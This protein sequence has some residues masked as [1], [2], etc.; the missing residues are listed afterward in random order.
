MAVP[1]AA[2]EHP[3][4][5]PPDLRKSLYIVEY[6]VGKAHRDSSF[7]VSERNSDLGI[8]AADCGF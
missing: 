2:A 5:G 7:P 4:Q 1:W 3:W 8:L 6:N